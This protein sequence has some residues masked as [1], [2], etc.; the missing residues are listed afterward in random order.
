MRKEVI[1]TLLLSALVLSLACGCK[2]NDTESTSSTNSKIESSVSS[3]KKSSAES[4]EQI[5]SSTDKDYEE[6]M[7]YVSQLSPEL[8]Y[9]E[10]LEIM[11]EPDERMGS[12]INYD[13]Y[14]FGRYTVEITNFNYSVT[15][16]DSET[17]ESTIIY[18]KYPSESSEEK[19]ESQTQ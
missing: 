14:K 11:G 17:K 13:F 5:E 3:S 9:E 1:A 15:I 18:S 6:M 10:V 4:S 2:N 19:P 8:T 7:K 16:Y 12:G